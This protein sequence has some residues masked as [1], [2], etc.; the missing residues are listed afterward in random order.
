M[1]EI[2]NTEVGTMNVQI[3]NQLGAVE[4][5]M[6]FRKDQNLSQVNIPV[7][8]FQSGIHFVKVQ[9]GTWTETKKLI[10]M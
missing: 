2:A 8:G 9:I 5:S 10:K 3:I 1:L 7:D 6:N 4:K